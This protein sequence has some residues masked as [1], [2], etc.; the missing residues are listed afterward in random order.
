MLPFHLLAFAPFGVLAATAGIGAGLS[1]WIRLATPTPAD[2]PALRPGAVIL[3]F[4][5]P[6]ARRA[7]P[8]PQL[9]RR[10]GA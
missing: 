2:Y 4:P 10:A 9:R 8:P 6:A 1:I 7:G 3:R 5:P